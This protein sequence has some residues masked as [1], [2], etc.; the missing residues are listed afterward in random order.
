MNCPKCGTVLNGARYCQQC[1]T[2]ASDPSAATIAVTDL[3]SHASSHAGT[4]PRLPDG[5]L[6]L[7]RTDLAKDYEI[8]EEIGRGGMA[9]VYRAKEIELGR[10]VAIKVL[11]PEMALTAS[12]AE[13][14]KREARMAA[15]L[16]HPNIIPIYRVGTGGRL[17]YIAMKFVEGRT[18]DAI[19]AQQRAL[20]IPVILQVLRGAAHAIAYAHERG[21]IHRDIKG[22]N[23]M[24]QSD[25]RPVV[26]DFGIA[27]VLTEKSLTVAGSVIGT[28]FFMSP[29]QCAGTAVGPQSDQYSLGIVGFEMLTGSVPFNAETLPEILQHHWFT[30]VPDVT[31]VRRD[32]PKELMAIIDR[33]LAKAPS[34]RFASTFELARALDL[35]PVPEPERHAGDAMLRQL[36]SGKSVAKLRTKTLPP[37]AATIGSKVTGARSGPNAAMR[38]VRRRVVLGAGTGMVAAAAGI[39]L[40]YS[41]ALKTAR[42]GLD[43]PAPASVANPEA[44]PSTT[45]SMRS[46]PAVANA[47]AKTVAAATATPRDTV[48]ESQRAETKRIERARRDSIARARSAEAAASI[49]AAV[50]TGRI[51]LRTDPPDAEILIDGRNVGRGVLVDHEVA[52]G[53][54]RLRITANGYLPFDTTITVQAG[55]T[56][57]LGRRALT[58]QQP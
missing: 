8:Q 4:G 9:V 54:H 42:D 31:A 37:L 14:F 21:I 17:F 10:T 16:D 18:L 55:E 45:D 27:R 39:G 51:R 44:T 57:P 52:A 5:L 34:D 6:E 50:G 56:T 24:I 15:A 22:A 29:E 30:E 33:C 25:G 41:G 43:V 53:S 13:R 49:A 11:P 12:M 46:A 48:A 38:R 47:P 3:S 35:V 32:V 23:I 58:S 7:V 19:I 40:W 2:V 36:A 28:P 1:G 20:P 26:S